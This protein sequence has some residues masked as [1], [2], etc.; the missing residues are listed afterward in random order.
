MS[1]NDVEPFRDIVASS[2]IAGY[3]VDEF[4]QQSNERRLLETDVSNVL[5]ILRF[6]GEVFI[7][8]GETMWKAI[9]SD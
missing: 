3:L 8:L 5:Y 1:S 9:L 6:E 4:G 7:F 2:T